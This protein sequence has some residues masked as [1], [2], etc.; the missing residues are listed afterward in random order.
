MAS[1][2]WYP[3]LPPFRGGTAAMKVKGEV[4]IVYLVADIS[5]D[6]GK[7]VA[8]VDTEVQVVFRNQDI[9]LDRDRYLLPLPPA[10]CLLTNTELM[11]L[12]L[13]GLA[14]GQRMEATPSQKLL[15]AGS[16]SVG[17]CLA[18]QSRVQ[19]PPP[20][21]TIFTLNGRSESRTSG[22]AGLADAP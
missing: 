19:H 20:R 9:T 6:V 4:I 12:I 17:F 3:A 11:L 22:V 16:G 7:M 2:R 10:V 15:K 21:S 8:Q 5:L 18:P 14:L 13:S 1:I